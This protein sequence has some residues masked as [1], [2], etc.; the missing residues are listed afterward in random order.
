MHVALQQVEQAAPEL[1][2][3]YYLGGTTPVACLDLKHDVSLYLDLH[4][5]EEL[6]PTSTE[7]TKIK[8]AFGSKLQWHSVDAEFGL[9]RGNIKTTFKGSAVVIGLNV[10]N[11]VESVGPGDTKAAPGFSRTDV[12]TVRKY[13]ATKIQCL[14][15]RQ[16]I[17][18]VYHLFRLSQNAQ[19]R[20]MTRNA[21]VRADP[22]IVIAAAK[23]ALSEWPRFKTQLIHLPGMAPFNE[24]DFLRWLKALD[25]EYARER[26]DGWKGG[27]GRLRSELRKPRSERG[28][29]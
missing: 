14:D 26:T 24:S 10:T 19:T 29:V 27:L 17:K 25:P 1:Q 12:I 2:R 15:E 9:Y 3:N 11:N 22:L 16:E 7:A 5:K 20:D 28:P 18:D 23:N 8:R 4:T 21:I 13:L 6:A